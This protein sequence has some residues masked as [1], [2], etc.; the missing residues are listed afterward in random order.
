MPAEFTSETDMFEAA[1]N[2]DQAALAMLFNLHR[3]HLER[4]V[5]LRLDRRLQRR[6]DPADVV[7]ET[8]LGIQRK[9][10]KYAS[11]AA[12]PLR[13][14]LRLE[15]GQTLIDVHR[16]H[17]G[18]KMRD[19]GQEISIHRGAYPS[20]ASKTLAAQLLG[21]VSTASKAAMRAEIQSKVQDALNEMDPHDREVL[22]LRHFEELSNSE[23]ASTLGITSSAACNRYV[24]AIKRLKNV[25]DQMPGGIEGVWS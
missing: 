20:V 13:I 8:Y 18:A 12:L 22:V 14:W 5:R 25:F 6:V 2:G 7:Q 9:F 21:R 1:K 11:D 15:V 19:A 3:A 24:R 17:L 10:A 4:M 16:R 23:V